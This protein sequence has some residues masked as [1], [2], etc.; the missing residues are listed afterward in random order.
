MHNGPEAL[1]LY[2][3]QEWSGKTERVSDFMC[4]CRVFMALNACCAA[5]MS[6]KKNC[7]VQ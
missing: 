5:L 3:Y 6:R 1:Q 4:M 2:I 7:S